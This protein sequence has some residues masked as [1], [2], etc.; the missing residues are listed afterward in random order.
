M[1]EM[2]NRG[3]LLGI[4]TFFGA[5]CSYAAIH[6]SRGRFW[7]RFGTVG[8]V[9]LGWII[10]DLSRCKLKEGKKKEY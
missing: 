3:R 9:G 7:A 6:I 4:I 8:I 10:V 1:D 2:V 5:R